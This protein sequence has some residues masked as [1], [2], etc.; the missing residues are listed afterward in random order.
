[1]R[2][3]FLNSTAFGI[4]EEDKLSSTI[5]H[6]YLDCITGKDAFS[7]LDVMLNEVFFIPLSYSFRHLVVIFGE[8]R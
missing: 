6:Y 5:F 1:M 3:M 7:L 4:N 2:K 8:S